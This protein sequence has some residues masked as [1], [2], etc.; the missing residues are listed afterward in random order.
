MMPSHDTKLFENC[1]V[2]IDVGARYNNYCSDQT[3]TFWFGNKIEPRFQQMLDQVKEAQ[4]EAIKI[5]HLVYHV[6][7]HT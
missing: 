4:E 7:K 5:L 2:L 3:R 1:H 6:M